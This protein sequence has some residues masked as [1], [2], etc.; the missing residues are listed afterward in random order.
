MEYVGVISVERVGRPRY[1]AAIPAAHVGIVAGRPY[2][3]NPAQLLKIYVK[4]RYTTTL[5]VCTSWLTPGDR[6][7]ALS[8]PAITLF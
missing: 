3:P 7:E 5:A 8:P 2:D 4:L 6:S 1:A